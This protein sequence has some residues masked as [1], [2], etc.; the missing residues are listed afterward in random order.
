M[1]STL[2][3]HQLPELVAVEFPELEFTGF[4]IPPQGLDHAVA[5]L[6]GG[7][8]GPMVARAPY[9]AAYRCQA[10]IEAAVID[11]ITPLVPVSLPRTLRSTP[12]G[13]LSVHSL[14]PGTP[15]DAD[16]LADL[17]PRREIP[18]RQL[19]ALLSALHSRNVTESP[20]A[21]VEPWRTA[22]GLNPAARAL[23][24]K[25]R[26]LR[27][28]AEA[29]LPPV[30]D[31]RALRDVRQI[32]TEMDVLLDPARPPRLIHGDL[33]DS[34]LLW[35]DATDRLGVI[36]FSDMN[37]GDPAVDFAHLPD[38]AA[39]LEFYTADPD[40]SILERAAIYRRWD[41]V[42]LLVDHLRTGRTAAQPAWA[43]FEQAR[44]SLNRAAR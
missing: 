6:S 23:P 25:I 10:P 2:H 35:D 30:L 41:A 44:D 24:A 31:D 26:L 32:F 1:T 8:S 40:E 11:E 28:R 36:D 21:R 16:V 33:Y 37:R 5:I 12:G 3:P 43:M 20:F 29:L 42:Y 38:P 39:V 13:E 9:T 34:H 15:L 19:A 27:Q 4:R 14:V 18:H 17:G 22:T 7:R